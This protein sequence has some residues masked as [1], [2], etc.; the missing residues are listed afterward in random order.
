LTPPILVDL[1]RRAT[2]RSA[3]VTAIRTS[4]VFNGRSIRIHPETFEALSCFLGQHPELTAEMEQFV[5]LTADKKR[6][7]D[8]GAL[9]GVFSLMFAAAG[10]ESIA[11]DASPLAFARLLYNVHAN[12]ELK[13]TPIERAVSDK[14]GGELRMNF[15]WEHA[16]ATTEEGVITSLSETA[17]D[18]CARLN[19]APDVI[20][21]D[22]E[23][24]EAQVLAGMNAILSN[25][26][27]IFLET[28]P[29]MF[30][31]QA[32]ERQIDRLRGMGYRS[33]GGTSLDKVLDKP[34]VERLALAA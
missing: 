5:K 32:L 34:S 12:P 20:K 2:G 19:F 26:P 8:I 14:S 16:V 1:A 17:D 33:V 6:L 29:G 7:L 21:I 27:L 31:R 10:K 25:R 28:H 18:I 24:H 9:Y 4:A 13:I 30:D 15:E 22:V 23:G 11:I 3:R